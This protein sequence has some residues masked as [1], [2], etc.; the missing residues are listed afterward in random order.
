MGLF[1]SSGMHG[2]QSDRD[3]INLASFDVLGWLPDFSQTENIAIYGYDKKLRH[4][5]ILQSIANCY[6][7]EGIVVL[8][9]N[10]E[11]VR[12][13]KNF[14]GKYPDVYEECRGVGQC[15][16][17]VTNPVYEPLFGM[18]AERIVEAIYP[19]IDRNSPSYMQQHTCGEVL[20]NYLRILELQGVPYD[21]DELIYLVNLDINELRSAELRDIDEGEARRITGA[22]QRGNSTYLQVR[23]DINAFANKLSGRIWKKKNWD[24][25]STDVSIITSVRE[26]SI[27]TIKIPNAPAVLNYISS[28]IDELVDNNE[29]FLL[30]IDSIAVAGTLLEEKLLSSNMPFSTLISSD[31]V[32]AVFNNDESKM[33]QSLGL[34]DGIV[35]MNCRNAT[36]AKVYSEAAGQ[37][38]REFVSSNRGSARQDFSI[39]AS[40]FNEGKTRSEQLFDRITPVEFTKLGSGA[41]IMD[42]RNST[43]TIAREV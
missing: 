1:K 41:V 38:M 29:N 25:E 20:R 36:D 2:G 5:V 14:S 17:G 18:S 30:V 13:I 7:Y 21:L 39:F 4:D 32:H 9:N 37:Y 23:D 28:E 8:H 6:G 33:S 15:H 11:L 34:M 24:E 12:D 31:R 3:V 27:L 22:L 19:E 10:D 35:I 40:S 26:K 42:Q 43:I 16:V